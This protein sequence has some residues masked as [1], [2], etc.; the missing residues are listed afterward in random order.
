M[1][2]RSEW[3]DRVWLETLPFLRLADRIHEEYRGDRENVKRIS[4]SPSARIGDLIGGT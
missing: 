1:R 3:P 2:R 4:A